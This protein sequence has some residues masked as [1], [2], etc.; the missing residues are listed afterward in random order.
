[1]SGILATLAGLSLLAFGWG[2]RAWRW[3][4]C[5]CCGGTLDRRRS[6]PDRFGQPLCPEC[7][8]SVLGS[9]DDGP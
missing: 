3:R 1:M 5:A 9:C 2:W 6:T 4:P 7:A 8:E